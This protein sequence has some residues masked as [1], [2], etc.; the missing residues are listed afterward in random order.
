M[1]NS[2]TNDSLLENI[3]SPADLKD[4]SI[5]DLEGLANEIRQKIIE[6]VSKTGGHLAPS[7]GVVE[8][9]IALHYVFNTPEDK[10]I[11]DVGHQ[12]YAH[13][14]ITG[15]RDRFHTLRTYGGISGF[16]KREESPYDSFD[17][18]HSSTSISAGLG[19]S[20]A[21]GLKG[22]KSKVISVI[23]DGSMTAGMAFEGLNQA[24]HHEKDLIV[25][26]NDNAMSI[27]PNVGS[28]SSFLSRKMTGR[29]FVNLKK[30]LE[31]FIKSLPGV[32]EN[33]LSL[34]RKS[35]DSFITFFTPGML[36]EAFKFKYIGPIRGH[37]IGRLIEAFNNTLHLEG[38][39]LV[40]VLT[41]KGKGYE[42][43]EKDP[44]HFHGVGSFEI[45][46]GST[47]K[48]KTKPLPSYTEIF[49]NT[50][51]D[52]ARTNKKLFAV[53]AAMPEG[54]GLS[55]FAEQYP[56]RFMDTGIAEQHAVTFAAGLATEGFRP[57]VAI[58]STFL[59]RAFDQVIHDVCLPNLPVIFAIDRG[60]LVGEDGPTHHGHFDITYLRSLPN[61]TVMAPK[62]ENELRQMLYT[63]LKHPGPVAIRYPRGKGLG[64]PID[65]K[66]QKIPIG[67]S[68]TLREG[69]DL[70]I[71]ALGNMVYPSMEAAAKLEKEGLSVGVVNCRFA[72]PLDPRLGELSTSI[73][74]V[75]VVE[76]NIRQGGLGGAVL[77]LFSDLG[78]VNVHMRRIGLPDKF[79][80]HGASPLLRKIYGL[81]T[82]G[83]LKEARDFCQQ[84]Q[85]Q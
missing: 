81:D 13:K 25:V 58:Y 6:T 27:S 1:S 43:A 36:F 57:V 22:E 40:H 4:L 35:E 21:K 30:D 83:I 23:G 46:T 50:M 75:L 3:N 44:A 24:G 63:A 82:T 32:G 2:K 53:T 79:V 59:Q 42:P 70:L 55:K 48:D 5:S 10:I 51:V 17:T 12:A 34:V 39:V 66:Y 80:E 71:L 45:P 9:T 31:G 14:L 78:I 7:L 84:A 68:E 33:I 28:F 52:L 37:R 41:K 19:I 77:E 65:R 26:L 8:L 85:K 47:P 29:R 61:M 62:D 18:G 54:T 72:K 76:E 60:G 16:P 20:T 64:V 11:W 38:P 74:R 67:Q 15:R 73:G 56:E 69:K 49:G